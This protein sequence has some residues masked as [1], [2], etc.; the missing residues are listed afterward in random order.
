MGSIEGRA[1]VQYLPTD[2]NSKE[3]F[4]FK[5]HRHDKG[6]VTDVYAVNAI[7]FH[8][9]KGVFATAGRLTSGAE[10]F[11]LVSSSSSSIQPLEPSLNWNVDAKDRTARL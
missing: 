3:S 11:A 1:G 7:A 10:A 4:T 9:P 2:P 5:C 6:N 8:K